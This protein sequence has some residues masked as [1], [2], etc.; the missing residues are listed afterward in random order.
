MKQRNIAGKTS[1]RRKHRLFLKSLCGRTKKWSL[2]IQL[3]GGVLVSEG[4]RC[5]SCLTKTMPF[6][7]RSMSFPRSEAVS[8]KAK[9]NQ[10]EP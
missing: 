5:R 1:W 4:R 3:Y 2:R 9:E 6:S 10:F 8:I 7:R